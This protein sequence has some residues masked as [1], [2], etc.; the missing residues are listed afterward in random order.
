[1]ADSITIDTRVRFDLSSGFQDKFSINMGEDLNIDLSGL[2]HFCDL[3]THDDEVCGKLALLPAFLKFG[4]FYKWKHSEGF[5]F[6]SL[7]FKL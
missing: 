7:D 2:E 3:D 4:E 1:M 5:F 6:L